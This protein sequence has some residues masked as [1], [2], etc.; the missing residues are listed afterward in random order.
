[1]QELHQAW[2][3]FQ[4]TDDIKRKIYREKGHWVCGYALPCQKNV[5]N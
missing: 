4:K 2:I 5:K 3:N 1:M